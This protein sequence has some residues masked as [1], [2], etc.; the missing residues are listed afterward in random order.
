MLS[1]TSILL[2][3]DEP[4]SGAEL[5][6][7]LRSLEGEVASTEDAAQAIRMARDRDPDALV[8][9]FAKL[10]NGAARA[11]GELRESLPALPMIVL[12]PEGAP[13]L[14]VEAMQSGASDFLEKPVEAEDLG[15]AILR[16]L[17]AGL[18]PAERRLARSA[19]MRA[20]WKVVDRVADTDVTVL[21]RGET[22]VGKNVLART[23]HRLSPRRSAPYLTVHCA[24][25]PAPLLESELFGYEKG[26][27]TGAWTRKPG[28][29]EVARG[30]TVLLDEIGEMSPPLQAKLL[31]VLQ[32]KRYT[33]I[34]GNREVEVDVRILCATNRNLEEM[35][36]RG[37]FREDLFYRINVVEL[38]IPPLR[39]RREE[40]PGL[41][42]AFLEKH[43]Q[44][45]SR[46]CPPVEADVLRLLSRYAFPGNVRELE[47]IAQ[48]MVV[49]GSGRNVV[50]EMLGTEQTD[51]LIA[52]RLEEEVAELER[53][54]GTVPLAEV[55]RRAA[56]AVEA[57]VLDRVLCLT[58]WNRKQAARMLGVSY[59]TLLQKIRDCGVEVPDSTAG[60]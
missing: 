50:R 5:V 20:I 25:L 2:L 45:R 51:E 39:E 26:A 58:E 17:P 24:A 53:T 30:G 56:R 47:N 44:A 38:E 6:R 18:G 29:F 23:L 9:D 21:L 28:K 12:A 46:P 8:L 11:V 13:R 43:A 36:A 60:A 19:A 32:D 4:R 52:R 40:I 42:Q 48:R 15:R 37:E 10:A 35:I 1:G 3:S 54:A 27:F 16:A 34:G 57:I 55:R 22:G 7:L 41:L 33:P 14:I 59:S 49:L 31:Q